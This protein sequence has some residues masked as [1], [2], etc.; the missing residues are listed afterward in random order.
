MESCV[1][2]E[3]P[4][5]SPGSLDLKDL[6]VLGLGI[7]GFRVEGIEALGVLGV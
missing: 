7:R 6:T 2:V 4:R 3:L 1:E 5:Y